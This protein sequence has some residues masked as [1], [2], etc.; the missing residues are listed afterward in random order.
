MRVRNR[1]R[2]TKWGLLLR[3]LPSLHLENPFPFILV[4]RT[5]IDPLHHRTEKLTAALS[6]FATEFPH[7]TL[8]NPHNGLMIQVRGC[9]ISHVDA[10]QCFLLPWRLIS[11]LERRTKMK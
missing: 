6:V 8:Q 10:K 4:L 9:T 2:T 7:F 3:N 11:A 1:G 5:L